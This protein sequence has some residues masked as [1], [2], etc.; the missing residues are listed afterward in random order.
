MVSSDEL[1]RRIQRAL[2]AV[3]G[4]SPIQR[5]IV[6]KRLLKSNPDLAHVLPQVLAYYENAKWVWPRRTTLI[7]DAVQ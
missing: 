4:L 3:R 5:D 7:R 2:A 6:V 1:E